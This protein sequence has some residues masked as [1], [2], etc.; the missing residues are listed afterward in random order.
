MPTILEWRHRLLHMRAFLER[1]CGQSRF[2]C[3]YIGLSFNSRISNQEGK[4]SW[5]HDLKK[6]CSQEKNIIRDP[7]SLKDACKKRFTGIFVNPFLRDHDFLRWRCLSQ[8]GRSCRTRF[9][10][11]NVRIRIFSITDKIGGSLSISPWTLQNHWENVLTSTK[12]C[13]H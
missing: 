4:T 9:H 3:I 10:L 12:R 7:W 11:S 8:M 2:H 13:L 6:R 1:N 5:P